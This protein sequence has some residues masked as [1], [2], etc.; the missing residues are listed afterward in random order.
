MSG[1]I[2]TL[3]GNGD[4]A[5]WSAAEK[6]IVEAAGLVFTHTYGDRQ[7]Q[8]EP[9]PRPVVERFLS[10]ARRSGLDP[11][12]R[13]IYCIGRLS[14]G[15]V[16]WSIQT[17]IDGFRLVADRSKKYAGQ[18]PAQWLTE[19]GEWVDAFVPSLH[20]AH[21]L[22]AR[23]TVY[24]SDWP[25]PLV[26]VAEWGAYAQTKRDGSLNEM[27][28]KQGPGQ[29]AKCAE[30]LALRKAFPQDLSGI[31]TADE[32]AAVTVDETQVTPARD[33]KGMIAKAATHDEVEDIVDAC[34]NAGELSDTVRT[35][36]LIRHGML[37]REENMVDAEVVEDEDTDPTDV[38]PGLQP[39]EDDD[40]DEAEYERISTQEYADAVARGE[41]VADD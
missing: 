10:L 1:E 21:P 6:A 16:E 34:D 15:R 38:T 33:W 4:V 30:A 24:R 18:D 35:A 8:R 17:G 25:R 11:L 27:W 13:Q 3:P 9:A 2:T 37:G 40:V 26:A 23:A 20:G 41:V 12:A 32:M 19:K 29:L 5:S 36:A 14:K 22:A 31:Y 28:T 7:G 39:T